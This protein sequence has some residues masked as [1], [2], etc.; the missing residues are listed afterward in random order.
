MLSQWFK[1]LNKEFPT[2]HNRSH[3]FTFSQDMQKV[4]LSILRGDERLIIYFDEDDNICDGPEKY[5]NDIRDY[6]NKP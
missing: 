3:S 1:I 2:E 5:I 6:Y 4:T